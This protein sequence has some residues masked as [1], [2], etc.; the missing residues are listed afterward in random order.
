MCDSGHNGRPFLR[1]LHGA[2]IAAFLVVLLINN[3]PL[4]SVRQDVRVDDHVLSAL[5]TSQFWS[6]FAPD[7]QKVVGRIRVEF[8]YRDGSRSTWKVEA[9]NPWTSAYRDYRWLKLAEN[10]PRDDRAAQGLLL[11]A[12]REH[13]EP[14][15]LARAELVRSVYDIAPP[16]RSASDHRPPDEGVLFAL[17]AG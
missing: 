15:P 11:Y 10:I 4:R 9:G 1:N 17:E 12:V 16:G 2:A 3:I 13:A 5:G 14:K 8:R 7:P 6:V